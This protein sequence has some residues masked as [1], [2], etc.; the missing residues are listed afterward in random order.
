M[1]FVTTTRA[2]E[3]R[4]A[5][6]RARADVLLHKLQK[7]AGVH[8]G[9]GAARIEAVYAGAAPVWWQRIAEQTV[10]A[11]AVLVL[12]KGAEQPLVVMTLAAAETLATQAEKGF[13]GK[14]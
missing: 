5:V 11:G 14:T 12:D 8:P 2:R 3:D 9:G 13:P 7:R 4:I 1:I 6:V 10:Q